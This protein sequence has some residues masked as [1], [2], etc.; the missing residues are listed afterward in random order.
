MTR[1][2]QLQIARAI[3]RRGVSCRP[4]KPH[5]TSMA[6]TYKQLQKQIEQL[7]RQAE[8]LRSKEV[9]GVVERIKVAIAHYGLT[10]A[11]LGL[12]T[13]ASSGKARRSTTAGKAK[14]SPAFA[15]S[16]GNAWSGRG[17]RPGWLKEALASGRSLEEFRVDGSGVAASATAS[18][19]T[20]AG[21]VG[22]A[23]GKSKRAP[24]KVTY[25]DDAGHSWTG[26]GPKPGWLKA[27]LDSG[28]TLQDFLK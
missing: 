22:K 15:D 9:T 11:H 2:F 8:S 13:P 1:L 25:R 20:K 28:K 26:R 4:F 6:L 19:S 16:H 12:E 24:S 27:A 21:K 17:P 10:A 7:Q 18:R 23:A 14:S 5:T 3:A